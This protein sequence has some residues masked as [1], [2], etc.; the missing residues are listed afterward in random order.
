MSDWTH[1]FRDRFPG[2]GDQSLKV[3]DL[4]TVTDGIFESF[5]GKIQAIDEE[6]GKV[7]IGIEI[8]G[9]VTPVEVDYRQVKRS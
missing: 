1:R 5:D 8:F 2:D 9:R 7:T 3:G 6:E 4:V